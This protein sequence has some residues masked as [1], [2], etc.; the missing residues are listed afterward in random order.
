MFTIHYLDARAHGSLITPIM[1]VVATKVWYH[2][3]RKYCIIDSR[4]GD[5][6]CTATSLYIIFDLRTQTTIDLHPPKRPAKN[7]VSYR[8]DAVHAKNALLPQENSPFLQKHALFPEENDKRTAGIA[9][10]FRVQS[11]R[12]LVHK[13]KNLVGN[14]QTTCTVI[15]ERL[16]CVLCSAIGAHQFFNRRSCSMRPDTRRFLKQDVSLCPNS[17]LW[18]SYWYLDNFPVVC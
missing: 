15:L 16:V 4:L 18:V 10:G 5:Q 14:P 8:K 7:G 3:G 2:W 9:R 12:T 11:L 6:I 17:V 13:H 1:R